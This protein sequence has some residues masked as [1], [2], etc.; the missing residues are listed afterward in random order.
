MK[1]LETFKVIVKYS[2][3]KENEYW[4]RIQYENKYKI[5]QCKELKIVPEFSE[6]SDCTDVIKRLDIKFYDDIALTPLCLSEFS[7][8]VNN[9]EKKIKDYIEKQED[10]S[11][12]FEDRRFLELL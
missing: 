5:L 8:M 10:I 11:T 7:E 12:A 4:I 1:E 2:E 3:G 9:N 6:P